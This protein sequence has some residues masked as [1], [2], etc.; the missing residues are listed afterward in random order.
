MT[1]PRESLA[2]LRAQHLPIRHTFGRMSP[3]EFSLR[4]G[5][6]LP[7][8]ITNNEPERRSCQLAHGRQINPLPASALYESKHDR[9]EERL[10]FDRE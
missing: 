4:N 9:P 5:L 6:R 1:P 2:K 8:H 7:I 10:S 3:N